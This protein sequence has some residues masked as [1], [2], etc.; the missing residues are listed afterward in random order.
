MPVTVLWTLGLGWH[1]QEILRIHASMQMWIEL[2]EHPRRLYLIAQPMTG[3]LDA[4]E[5]KL[6]W[7]HASNDLTW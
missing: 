5:V 7:S 2:R 3:H 6:F 4:Q 1:D